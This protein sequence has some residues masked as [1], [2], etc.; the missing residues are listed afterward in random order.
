MHRTQLILEDWQYDTLKSLS[1]RRGESLSNVVRDAVAEYL[2][3]AAPS[4]APGLAAIEGIGTDSETSGR[5]HDRFLYPTRKR[6]QRR[7]RTGSGRR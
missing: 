4:A 5:E 1:E 6:R 7:E 2:G 3:K